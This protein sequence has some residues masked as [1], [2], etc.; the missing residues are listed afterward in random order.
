M[1]PC[2]HKRQDGVTLIELMIV[3]AIIG[4]LAV[5]A[6]PSYRDYVTRAQRAEATAGLLRLAANQ[7][8]FYLQNNTYSA[9]PVALGFTGG[10]TETGLYAM[11]VVGNVLN[12]TA[13]ATPVAGMRQA[14]DVDCQSFTINSAGVRTS[15]P[16]PVDECWAGR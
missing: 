6:I 1:K 9:D 16:N 13:T 14:T 11:A 10:R 8:R 4:A 12:F 3:V 15:G 2:N 7:E 5:I